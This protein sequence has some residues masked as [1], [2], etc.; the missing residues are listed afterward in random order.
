MIE[1]HVIKECSEYIGVNARKRKKEQLLL[2]IE[3]QINEIK[4]LLDDKRAEMAS[5][6]N[7]LLE[8]QQEY[9]LIPDT[10]ELN[11]ILDCIH[12]LEVQLQ[13]L[14]DKQDKLDEKMNRSYQLFKEAEREMLSICKTL[15]YARNIDT[16]E[17]IL[18]AI[19]SYKEYV[20]DLSET[21]VQKESYMAQIEMQQSMRDTALS[22]M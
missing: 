16:Y 12:K 20:H 11:S 13:V 3:K 6:E 22:E 9:S 14:H 1:G 10:K 19:D 18:N 21:L 5:E 4:Q 17:D 2:N 15:P 8:M 7:D